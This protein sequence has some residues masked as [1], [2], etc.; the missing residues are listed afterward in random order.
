[1]CFR[2]RLGWTMTIVGC[3]IGV[4]L[5]LRAQDAAEKAPPTP[6]DDSPPL[7]FAYDPEQEEGPH[8]DSDF[9]WWYHF[10][11]LKRT[12]AS[13]FE[14][15]LVSSFQRNKSGR[16]LFYNLSDLTTGKNLHYAI[17]DRSLFGVT[18]QPAASPA[19]GDGATPPR[20]AAGIGQRLAHWLQDTL[21]L[22]PEGH[23]F[24]T[25]PGAPAESPKSELWLDYGDHGFHKDGSAY[26]AIYKNPAFLLDLAWQRTGPALPV[27]GTGLTGLDKPED[28]HYYTYPR[29]S[30][31]G[32]LRKGREDEQPVEGSFW[33][34]H[35]W[36]KVVGTEPMKWCW[37]GLRLEDG[38]NLSLFFL[39]DSRSGNTVQKGLTVQNPDGRIEV[40]KDLVFT[41]RRSWKSPHGKDY[42]VEWQIE[43]RE[44]KLTMQIRAYSDDHELPVLLYGWIWEGPCRAEVDLPGGP[45][46]KGVGFQEMIG[47]AHDR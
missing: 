10:G 11:F 7:A 45:T 32:L 30:A 20:A 41:P 29:M 26:R 16:Y 1:M 24:M 28:Q 39:Q 42:N 22:L 13:E 8:P 3:I 38:R 27:L 23:K 5:P 25:P 47:Q 35:Q 12:G 18:D 6:I 14:Y 40:Y 34:D 21:P 43:S 37:W 2:K 19:Q 46:V 17:V 31:R 44:I 33:Y 15:S 36:G 9:E 4:G